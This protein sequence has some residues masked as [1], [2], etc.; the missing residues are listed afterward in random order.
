MT[1]QADTAIIGGGIVGMACAAALLRRFPRRTLVVLEKETRVGAHQSSHNSGVIHSGIYYRPE[2]LKAKL[3]VKG[4][5]AM[6]EFCRTY[7]LPLR[8]CG[9]VIVAVSDAEVPTLHELATRGAANRVPD[10]AILSRDELHTLEPHAAGVAALQ[11]PGTAITD[12]G[13]VTAKLAE[14]VEAAGG[15]VLRAA[16]VTAIVA[17][18]SQMVLETTAGS[19][20]ATRIVNCAG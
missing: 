11:V 3:C 19:I 13:K 8:V 9:K 10:L 4:A 16:K 2:S 15:T 18:A 5:A 6:Q 12:Y 1:V 14:R 7:D 17:S 20:T